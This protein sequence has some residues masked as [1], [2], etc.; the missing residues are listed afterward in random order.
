MYLNHASTLHYACTVL[1]SRAAESQE[2]KSGTFFSK[3]MPPFNQD[4][5]SPSKFFKK[6]S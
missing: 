4:S 6:K 1:L 2:V 3:L 5:V